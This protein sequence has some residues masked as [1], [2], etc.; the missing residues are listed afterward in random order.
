MCGGQR[1]SRNDRRSNRA[2]L[3][4]Q[5]RHAANDGGPSKATTAGFITSSIV[6]DSHPLP[7]APSRTP[8]PGLGLCPDLRSNPNLRKRSSHH[9]TTFQQHSCSWNAPRIIHNPQNARHL[10][11]CNH[12]MSAK[13]NNQEPR[14][15]FHQH[16]KLAALRQCLDAPKHF[17]ASPKFTSSFPGL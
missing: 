12:R 14:K 5:R 10:R 13:P 15:G 16:A 17:L 4:P 3:Q 8:A 11:R 6:D 9:W 2:R 7:N 1:R